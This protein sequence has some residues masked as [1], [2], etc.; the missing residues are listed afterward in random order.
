MAALST[1]RIAWTYT[2]DAGNQCR[3]AAQK[4]LTD[5]GVLS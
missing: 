5:Q 1:N 2:D 3:V 4:P